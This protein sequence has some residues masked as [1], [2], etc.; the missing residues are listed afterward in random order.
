M[1][2]RRNV[3]EFFVLSEEMRVHFLESM[4]NEGWEYSGVTMVCPRKRSPG[5]LCDLRKCLSKF[6]F[7]LENSKVCPTPSWHQLSNLKGV[8]KLSGVGPGC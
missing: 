8:E 3:D 2:A 1:K 7:G 6:S 4:E 5:E